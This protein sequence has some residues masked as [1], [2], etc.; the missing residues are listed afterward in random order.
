MPKILCVV[1]LIISALVF[2]L[3]TLNM[4]AGVP[5]GGVGGTWG[6]LGMMFGA[7]MI[8]VFSFLTLKECR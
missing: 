6:H 5:F 2:L 1:S 3:F 7:I 4:V 8:G